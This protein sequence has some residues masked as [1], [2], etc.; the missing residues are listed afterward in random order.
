MSIINFEFKGN[1]FPW[2][3]LIAHVE[4]KCLQCLEQSFLDAKVITAK[5]MR[6]EGMKEGCS[7]NQSHFF[8]KAHLLSHLLLHYKKSSLDLKFCGSEGCAPYS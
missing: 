6:A 3:A 4:A 5:P 7:S 2:Q 1:Q 8:D